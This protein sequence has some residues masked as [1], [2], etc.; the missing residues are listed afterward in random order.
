MNEAK[1]SRTFGVS[2]FYIRQKNGSKGILLAK[3][4]DGLLISGSVQDIRNFTTENDQR[5]SVSKTI[6]DDEIKFSGC[7]IKQDD[8]CIIQ[9]SMQGYADSIKGMKLSNTRKA[10]TKEVA[11]PSEIRSCLQAAGELIWLGCGALPQAAYVA[12]LMQQRMSRLTVSLLIDANK[13]LHELRNL[14]A[15]INFRR[16]NGKTTAVDI[17]SFSDASFNLSPNQIYG[18]TGIVTGLRYRTQNDATAYNMID[19]CSSKQKRVS[20]SPYGAEIIA[21]TEADDRGF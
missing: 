1:F 14:R 19:Y 13:M 6:I 7:S 10:M 20:H 5:F 11:Q 15:V 12:S 2:Q 18:Q 3:L 8:K 21:Y 4:T 16:L 9:L 17:V